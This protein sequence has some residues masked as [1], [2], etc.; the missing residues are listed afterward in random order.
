MFYDVLVINVLQSSSFGGRSELT[1]CDNFK[2]KRMTRKTE[3]QIIQELVD[4]WRWGK[5]QA[6]RGIRAD[7][8]CEYCDKDLLSSVEN[9]KE[10]QED[11]IVPQ[12]EEGD[13]I[14]ENIAVSCRTCNVNIKGRWNPRKHLSTGVEPVREN[15]IQVV[16]EYVVKKRSEVLKEVSSIRMI[17]LQ[18]KQNH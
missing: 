11:H 8:K 14:D 17:A 3:S 7:F 16:R 4:E 1:I 12:C 9:Y 13:D 15:L 10:W 6:K 2:K 5:E 18:E